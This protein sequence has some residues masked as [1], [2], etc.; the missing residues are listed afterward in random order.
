MIIVLIFL[1]TKTLIV[2]NMGNFW[3]FNVHSMSF[4]ACSTLEKICHNQACRRELIC[5]VWTEV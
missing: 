5:A 3:S 4:G 2:D 1:L